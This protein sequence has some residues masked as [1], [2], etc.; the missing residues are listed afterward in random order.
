MFGFGG[1]ESPISITRKRTYLLSAQLR[2]P[3]ITHDDA[4]TIRDRAG[5]VALVKRGTGRCLPDVEVDV[6]RWMAGRTF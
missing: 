6:D 2:W 5:L 4:A 3:F 1:G